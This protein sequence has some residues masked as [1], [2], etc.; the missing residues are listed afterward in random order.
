MNLDEGVHTI[1]VDELTGIVALGTTSPD[2]MP[3]K[4]HGVIKRDC[5]YMRFGMVTLIAGKDIGT[6]EEFALVSDTHK[7]CDFIEFLKLLD[8][9]YPKGDKIRLVLDNLIVHKSKAVKAFLATMPGRFELVFTPIHGSWLNLVERFFSKI[10][11]QLLRGLRV[12]SKEELVDL[13]YEYF[14]Q[15]NESPVPFKW[16]CHMDEFDPSEK[17]EIGL[18][19]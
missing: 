15:D 18:A 4:E 13:I 9:R 14:R 2:L 17:V 8:A 6:G 11:R 16:N 10:R 7:A 3:T 19:I 12:K 1:S 5:E